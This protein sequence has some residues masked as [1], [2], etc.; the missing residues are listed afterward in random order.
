M[1]P[2]L[3]ALLA[4]ACVWAPPLAIPDV[5]DALPVSLALCVTPVLSDAAL[6]TRRK[7]KAAP[8]RAV[9]RGRWRPTRGH[10][11]YRVHRR[12]YGYRR[13]YGYYDADGYYH[14]YGVASPWYD[15]GAGYYDANGY[16]HLYGG[17]SPYVRTGKGWR[18]RAWPPP[19]HRPVNPAPPVF[20]GDLYV[21]P[22]VA[23][24]W[25]GP[26]P[27]SPVLARLPRQTV[28]TNMGRYGPYY[29]VEA[30]NGTVGFVPA[31]AVA[32]HSPY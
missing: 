18:R 8:R 25:H 19:L 32:P 26:T 23:P 9:A 31:Y 16:Y 4:L 2:I 22:S 13:P 7:T 24:L 29:K 10:R 21:V 27:Y 28:V 5:A 17:Y 11:R 1:R 14:P 6:A 3:I 12:A 20:V 15:D 30:P